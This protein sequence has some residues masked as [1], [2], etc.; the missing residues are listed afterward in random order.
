MA[1]MVCGFA[2]NVYLWQFT[3]APFTWYVA[4]GSALTFVVGYAAS[5]VLVET[6]R[7]EE[8]KTTILGDQCD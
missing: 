5:F 8:M 3:K 4:L 1:G 2:L 6:T 7:P